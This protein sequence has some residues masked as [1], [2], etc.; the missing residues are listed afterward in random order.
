MEKYILDFEKPIAEMERKIAEMRELDRRGNL[1][2]ADEIEKL[3][4]KADQM[5]KDVFAKLGPWERVQLARHPNRPYSL[6]YIFRMVEEFYEF[7]GD[8]RFADDKAIVA[9]VG[10]IGDARMA[11]IGQQKGKGTKDNLLR[12][13]GMPHPE[14]YRKALRVMES[15][16]KYNRP[17]LTLIDTPGAYPGI[18]AEERGQAEAIAHNLIVMAGL[19]VPIIAVVIGEGGSGGALALGVA[20]RVMML[21][22]SIYSVI[23]PEGCASILYRDSTKNKLAAESLKITAADLKKLKLIDEII[24]EP[25]GGAHSDYDKAAEILKGVILKSLDEL[26]SKSGE[27][28]VESRREKFRRMGFWQ[29]K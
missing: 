7:H 20:D 11:V 8:R 12:N 15:A 5:K 25:P 14:G 22:N 10:R 16:A 19:P 1:K 28:L 3:Q 26:Q 27:E 4:A 9:G 24:P 18:G 21:E 23:S 6:D 29:E 2:A 17:I 13:F